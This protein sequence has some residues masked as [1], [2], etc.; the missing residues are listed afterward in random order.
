MQKMEYQYEEMI[1]T[2]RDEI[3]QLSIKESES[4]TEISKN[5]LEMQTK[6]NT[7]IAQ[8]HE[9]FNEIYKLNQTVDVLNEDIRK[10]E[11]LINAEK[12]KVQSLAQEQEDIISQLNS[13]SETLRGEMENMRSNEQN[14]IQ[15]H[16][17]ESDFLRHQI[18][19]AEAISIEEK[20]TFKNEIQALSNELND[21]IN[22]INLLEAKMRESEEHLKEAHK[23]EKLELTD[24]IDELKAKF[25]TF[26]HPD[27]LQGEAKQISEGGSFENG[28]KHALH[29][30]IA[31]MQKQ[32][33]MYKKD[34]EKMCCSETSDAELLKQNE[35]FRLRL[36]MGKRAFDK[37]YLECQKMRNELTKLRKVDNTATEKED[38]VSIG[39]HNDLLLQYNNLQADS[40]KK[41][42][43][44]SAEINLCEEQRQ[45][46]EKEMI[47][48]IEDKN[49][50]VKMNEELRAKLLKLV[51]HYEG[52]LNLLTEENSMLKNQVDALLQGGAN[53]YSVQ[54]SPDVL[55]ADVTPTVVPTQ[56]QRP[57]HQAETTVV[58]QQPGGVSGNSM[59][60]PSVVEQQPSHLLNVQYPFDMLQGT[61][62]AHRDQIATPTPVNTPLMRVEPPSQT[63]PNRS[64]PSPAAFAP[65]AI[66]HVNRPTEKC[67]ICALDFPNN[68]SDNWKTEHVNSHFDQQ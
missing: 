42:D 59:L 20:A 53:L 52:K 58:S 9:Y 39:E 47:N 24:T 63:I 13:E 57:H 2:L 54:R 8:K 4:A 50:A 67:P 5:I 11:M 40:T 23:Q 1:G 33:N 60:I 38:K 21:K 3:E 30:A 62:G 7:E 51:D 22:C 25:S 41:I 36:C 19:E 55:P 18:A 14:L 37:Q 45:Q 61:S 46:S 48:I 49:N 12:E 34:K 31:H 10:K 44:L 35:E 6:L 65:P 56:Q 17:K 27:S 66:R 15:A 64:S 29:V 32:L 16:E 68:L 43:E 28:S 26:D